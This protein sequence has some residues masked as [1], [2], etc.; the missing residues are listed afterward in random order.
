LRAASDDGGHNKEED[1]ITA[2]CDGDSPVTDAESGR[3]LDCSVDRCPSGTYCRR[4]A[5][6]VAGRRSTARCCPTGR[7]RL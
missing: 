3:L 6:D 4:S 7:R 1:E 2:A 5:G